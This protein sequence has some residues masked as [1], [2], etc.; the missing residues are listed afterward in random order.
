MQ[1]EEGLGFGVKKIN[2]KEQYIKKRKFYEKLQ[3]PNS[4]QLYPAITSTVAPMPLSVIASH[5]GLSV[6]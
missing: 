5:M 6:S 2:E 3:T 4:K 1:G